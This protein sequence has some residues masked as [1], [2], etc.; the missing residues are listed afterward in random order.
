MV[1]QPA[2]AQTADQP[3]FFAIV[4]PVFDGDT[5]TGTISAEISADG[6][7]RISTQS[8]LSVLGRI[9]GP[10]EFAKLSQDL[11]GISVI[12]PEQV[13]RLG[14]PIRFDAQK[15]ALIISAPADV[16]ART[17]LEFTK[18]DSEPPITKSR[19]I[20]ENA[21]GYLNMNLSVID[22]PLLGAGRSR[23]ELL[24]D[25]AVRIG[26][27]V[28]EN[29]AVLEV[30][31]VNDRFISR[32]GTRVT[33]DFAD[34]MLRVSVGDQTSSSVGFI[35]SVDLLGVSA[36]RN[37]EIF[38]SFRST[39]PTGRQS[40]ILTESANVDI[41]INGALARQERLTA[42][43]YDLANFQLVDGANDVRVEA[44]NDRGESQTFTFTNFFNA[45]L[46]APGISQWE[47]N[48]GFRAQRFDLSLDY[49]FN[50]PV[51]AGFYRR[52]ASD[53]L[54]IGGNFKLEDNQIIAGGEAVLALPIASLSV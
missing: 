12:G 41:Y 42:G 33:R 17:I 40:F 21:S 31:G 32:R 29:A 10:A 46:L 18:L 14:L 1:H 51:I 30:G 48:A 5:P 25:N 11:S 39:R 23:A 50:K 2:A 8:L 16:R 22:D 4:I 52:G 9:Y 37:V 35:G 38:Q 27:Y 19:R 26:D 49:E 20:P 54:T 53:T 47:I 28:F 44:I 13:A 3:G 36:F 24:L 6:N 7:Y 34:S 43:N 45:Q 15:V